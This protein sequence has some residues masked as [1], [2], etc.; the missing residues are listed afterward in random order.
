MATR[1]GTIGVVCSLFNREITDPMLERAVARA[2]ARGLKV[3][4]VV[5]VPG[6]FE[7]PLASSRLLRRRDIDGVVALGAVVKGDT[8]HDQVIMYSVLAKLLD[9]AVEHDKP[10]GLGVAGPGMSWEQAE[11]RVD[12]GVRAVD[13]VASMLEAVPTASGGRR[14]ARS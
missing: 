12:Y 2:R 5:R 7:I 9:L 11:A 8:D 4:E 10:L 14:Q 13:A 1:T 3:A 6:A